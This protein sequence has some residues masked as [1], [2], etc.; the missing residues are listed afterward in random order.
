MEEK[1]GSKNRLKKRDP[2]E[3]KIGYNRWAG[4]RGM[5]P[6]ATALRLRPVS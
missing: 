4:G 3:K 5:G 6:K 2:N 1:G